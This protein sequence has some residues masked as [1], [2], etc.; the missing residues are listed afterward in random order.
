LAVRLRTFPVV[1][2]RPARYHPM[3]W[4]LFVNCRYWVAIFQQTMKIAS[5]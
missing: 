5:A 4:H 3:L 1:S 2:N